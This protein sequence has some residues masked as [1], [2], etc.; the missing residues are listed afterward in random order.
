MK[1]IHLMYLAALLYLLI[2]CV[3]LAKV[4]ADNAS[5]SP[6]TYTNTDAPA[7]LRTRLITGRGIGTIETGSTIEGST[8]TASSG[9]AFSSLHFR[10]E[11]EYP[12]NKDLSI[13]LKTRL[14]LDNDIK[15]SGILGGSCL[16]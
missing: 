3:S 16:H 15:V 1:T 4:V 5:L 11:S 7:T 9:L 10:L 13:G 6:A 8:I 12:L 14:Q 2:P